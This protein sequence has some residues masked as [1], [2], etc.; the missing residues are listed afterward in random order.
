MSVRLLACIRVCPYSHVY[1]RACIYVHVSQLCP[2]KGPRS[3]D[4]PGARSTPEPRSQ[5][6]KGTGPLGDMADPPLGWGWGCETTL[7]HV[8]LERESELKKSE[9]TRH[10]AQSGRTGLPPANLGQCV[11]KSRR[12][13]TRHRRLERGPRVC[14]SD[15]HMRGTCER[16]RKGFL[17][18]SGCQRP[19]GRV[20]TGARE[21]GSAFAATRARRPGR[22]LRWGELQGAA[23]E[24]HP[25]ESDAGVLSTGGPVDTWWRGREQRE[26]GGALGRDWSHRGTFGA[27]DRQQQLKSW[28][29]HLSRNPAHKH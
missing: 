27:P 23:D 25:W 22:N 1:V 3:K 10:R 19:A 26:V 20:R 15:G 17:S 24:Q 7:E 16:G 21:T 14:A 8:M 5:P 4:T 6:L 11:P 9:R 29:G 2:P 28:T 13:V 12:T 18:R